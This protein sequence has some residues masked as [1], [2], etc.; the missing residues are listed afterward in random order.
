M[1]LHALL[2]PFLTLLTLTLAWTKEDHEIFRLRDELIT[3]HGTNTTFYTFLGVSPSASLDE[4]NK[5]YRSKS[6]QLHPD[7]AVPALLAERTAA[8]KASPRKPGS[9]PGVHVQKGP[10]QKERAQ[11]LK[12]ANERYARLGVVISILRGPARER[13]DHFLAQGFP[14]WKGTGY[15]YARFRP[16]LGSVLA[17]L[18]VLVGGAVHYVALYIGWKRHK[19][20]VERYIEHAKRTAWGDMGM[21]TVDSAMN[22]TSG[23]PTPQDLAAMDDAQGGALNRRQKR[24]QE[25][26]SKKKDS[27]RSA[28]TARSSGVSRPV[29]AEPIGQGPMGSRKK[30]IAENGKVLI[31]DSEGQV[32]LEETTEEGDTHELLLDVSISRR[33]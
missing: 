5:K 9:K 26:E 12:F 3:A 21:P 14:V 33:I 20:F 31:V 13:Y 30:I 23:L 2:L 27:G 4:I 32:F 24:M 16:G 18:A 6:R 19:D 29:D 10:T 28:K 25:K 15:Y 7:K 1:R 11:V 17:S 22:G 8:R